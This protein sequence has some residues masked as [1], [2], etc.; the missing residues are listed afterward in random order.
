[1]SWFCEAYCLSEW[2]CPQ[3]HMLIASEQITSERYHCLT[4]VD[5]RGINKGSNSAP[6]MGSGVSTFRF[7][8]IKK[9]ESSTC[10]TLSNFLD[11]EYGLLSLSVKSWEIV[12]IKE[13]YKPVHR[14][15]GFIITKNF[16]LTAAL[17]RSRSFLR[18]W[19]HMFVR[20][21]ELTLLHY[22][23]P[24]RASWFTSEL[25]PICLLQPN[26][27]LKSRKRKG[28]HLQDIDN[29]DGDDDEN[30]DWMTISAS[31]SQQKT[32]W[33]SKKL[34]T[35]QSPQMF[36]SKIPFVLHSYHQ[37]TQRYSTQHS[38]VSGQ[39]IYFR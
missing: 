8:V 21:L 12:L 10:S 28:V 35:H 7:C 19:K 2:V 9:V 18:L 32:S 11:E 25:I 33:S 6:T 3:F 37:E 36:P 5:F 22:Y 13:S 16:S 15:C 27:P 23:A 29:S 26:V 38:R 1:M 24:I 34:R 39:T 14:P 20:P 4:G 30:C 31:T 17:W